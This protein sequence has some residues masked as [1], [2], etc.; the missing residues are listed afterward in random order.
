MTEAQQWGQ[1]LIEASRQGDL[2]QVIPA[3][4]TETE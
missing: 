4:A 3:S 1:K 2:A